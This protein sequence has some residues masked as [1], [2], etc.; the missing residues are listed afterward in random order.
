MTAGEC[1]AAVKTGPGRTRLRRLPLP[2]VRDAGGLLRVEASGVC[3]ADVAWYAADDLPT[4]QP[5]VLGHHVV[6][7]VEK[8]SEPAAERLGLA[9]GD[10]VMVEE[11]LPCGVCVPCRSGAP[12]LCPASAPTGDTR[13]YGSTPV[14]VGPGLW[15][16]YSQYLYLD[17]RAMTHR[18]P[19]DL[20][21][22]LATLVFPLANGITWV[23][24]AGAGPG[25]HVV[26]IGPGQMGLS[27]VVAARAAGVAHITVLGRD[28]D[29]ARL[30]LARRLGADHA[31][32]DPADLRRVVAEA[33]GGRMANAVVETA[34]G[35]AQTLDLAVDLLGVDG[36][37]AL[38]QWPPGRTGVDLPA[39]AGKRLTVTT[40]R[41]RDDASIRRAI[42]LVRRDAA[43]L[44]RMC[45][46]IV[47]L[48]GLHD[49]LV[50][51]ASAA[52]RSDLV[53]VSVRG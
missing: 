49:V 35:T 10:R 17:E 14:T 6:G 26:V 40:V 47:E 27:C 30:A 23:R 18:L 21:T 33:T 4:R 16:G 12:R 36:T 9:P 22:E 53:H 1:L 46:G 13:R 42:E 8:I 24:A 15:G 31:T 48:E 43:R 39:L 7:T 25:D 20:P 2:D 32:T 11:Y 52:G 41:G 38:A 19:P 34:S 5:V 3:G 45:S 37:L 44:G 28:G 29:D 51:L 50:A